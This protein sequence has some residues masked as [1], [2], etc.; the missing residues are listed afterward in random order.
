MVAV[1]LLSDILIEM[2][3]ERVKNDAENTAV[4]WHPVNLDC[5]ASGQDKH[6]FC[7]VLFA[8]ILTGCRFMFVHTCC[9]HECA[10]CNNA[11]QGSGHILRLA[12][13]LPFSMISRNI[14]NYNRF[15]FL[16]Q[17]ANVF[18]NSLLYLMSDMCSWLGL[19]SCQG[20]PIKCWPIEY[21]EKK[22]YWKKIYF[23]GSIIAMA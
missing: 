1:W 8:C 22:K 10:L 13:D 15:I 12:T 17:S 19:C 21:A 23:L 5:M 3:L 4:F 14:P 7:R 18:I 9:L 20:A 6:L 11:C 2:G 16:F